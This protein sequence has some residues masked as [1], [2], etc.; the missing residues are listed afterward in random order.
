MELLQGLY[1]LRDYIDQKI[2]YLETTP[3]TDGVHTV[4]INDQVI[5]L[6]NGIKTELEN[7]INGILFN[8]H[9]Q[10]EAIEYYTKHQHKGDSE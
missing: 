9:T 5:K 10:S 3:V 7:V 1:D 8:N 2:D 6:L 4:L